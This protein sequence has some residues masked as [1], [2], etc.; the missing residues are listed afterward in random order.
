MGDHVHLERKPLESRDGGDSPGYR[1]SFGN[2]VAL[3]A[4]GSTL[5]AGDPD[6]NSFNGGAASV[7]DYSGTS[8]S[9]GTALTPP[10]SPTRLAR[11]SR[12]RRTVQRR[13]SG[14]PEIPLGA[15]TVYTYN[16]TTWSPGTALTPPAMA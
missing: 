12:F 3:S 4:S 10:A 5:L 11:R 16:G 9:A 13:S 15:A 1:V 2:A 8:L 7:Y 6:G 14:I